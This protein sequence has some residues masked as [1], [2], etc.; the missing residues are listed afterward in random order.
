MVRLATHHLKL[1]KFYWDAVKIGSKSFEVRR[2][3]RGFQRGDV[4]VFHKYDNSQDNGGFCFVDGRYIKT[5]LGEE[6]RT[7]READ[8]DKM[9]AEISYILTGGQFGIEP[10]YV[11]LGLAPAKNACGMEVV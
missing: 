2:D 10:G 3:D 8:S 4:V 1:D 7:N 9:K 6:L 11:V 5:C